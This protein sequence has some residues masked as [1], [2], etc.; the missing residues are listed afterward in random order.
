M[1]HNPLRESVTSCICL[2][3]VSVRQTDLK[4]QEEQSANVNVPIKVARSPLR[5]L[6]GQPLGREREGRSCRGIENK[7]K[8][9]RKKGS[10]EHLLSVMSDCHSPLEITQ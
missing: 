7:A 4:Q 8:E 2:C 5:D 6:R 1:T 3:T 10:Q 9:Q